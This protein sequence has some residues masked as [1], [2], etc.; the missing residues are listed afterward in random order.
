MHETPPSHPLVASFLTR[1]FEAEALG[2]PKVAASS[3]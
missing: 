3:G 1:R 2:K